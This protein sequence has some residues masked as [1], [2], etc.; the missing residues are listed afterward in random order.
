MT[1]GSSRR[2]HASGMMSPMPLSAARAAH[3]SAVTFSEV[4]S[5]DG[6][7]LRAWTNDP[8]QQVGGPTV[9]LCNGLGTNPYHWPAFLRPDSGVRVVSW[10]H[11]GVGGSQR[12]RDSE[13][14]R[15]ENFVEDA[16][17]V[18]DHFSLDRPVV[19]GW[20]MGVNTAFELV[21]R[22]PER[23]AA[24]F[25]VSGVPGDTFATMLAPLHVPHLLARTLTVSLA[26]ALTLGGRVLSPATTRYPFG[27]RSL[28]ALRRVGF[29]GRLSDPELG[30]LA[31]TEMLSTPVEW[32]MHL[33]LR[34]SEH[35]RVSL[36]SI[37]V[38]CTFVGAS[39]DLLAGARDM[40]SAAR[41]IPHAHYVELA[42]THFVQMEQPDRVHQLLR[43]LVARA[44]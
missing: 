20:S 12:P 7:I 33:A 36:S 43:E 32:Y 1:R 22:H 16:L 26:R 17:S 5:D 9:L 29:I 31:F 42:G 44:A 34:T 27:V 14:V 30:A 38:P 15:I 18:M 35:A 40:A 19:M 6:T 13:Q 41:R 2:S 3:A 23:V 37:D 8:D 28:E 25:A 21:A 24:L 11:R 10:N 39:R 4:V